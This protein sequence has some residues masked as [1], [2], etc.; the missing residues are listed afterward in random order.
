MKNCDR[1]CRW[2]KTREPR[3]KP[4]AQGEKQQQ[5]EPIFDTG[6]ELNPGH[7]GGK[8][9]RSLLYLYLFIPSP[10]DLGPRLLKE[11]F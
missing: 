11:Q 5:T 6:P 10:H 8:L 9:A 4:L 1:F 3:E 2:S 7:T